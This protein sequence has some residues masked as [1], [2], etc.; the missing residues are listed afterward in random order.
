MIIVN[1]IQEFLWSCCRQCGVS[2]VSDSS[3]FQLMLLLKVYRP[4]PMQLV[5]TTGFY[6]VAPV[7][8]KAVPS[9]YFGFFCL[10]VSSVSNFCPDTR[11]QRWSLIQA[12]LFSCAV[13]R[14]EHC[15]Q[16]SL[17]C[18]GGVLT[19]YGP[20]LVCPS[21]WW[22]VLSRSVLLRFQVSLQ[23][24]YSN[25][26]LRFRHFPGLSYSGSG[27]QVLSKGTDSVGHAFC[28]LPRSEQL[29]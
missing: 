5:L 26:A 11:G 17:S 2:S 10:Q 3:S 4:L 22:H 20:H 6:S 29:R 18:V 25:L 24:H 13:G 9:V 12:H 1:Y 28:A 15:K 23:G 8:S 16:L 14:E 19:V 21:S 7:T 27:P